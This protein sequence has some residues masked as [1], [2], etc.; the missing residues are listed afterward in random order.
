MRDIPLIILTALDERDAMIDSLHAGADDYYRSRATSRCSR[1]GCAR[2]SAANSSRTSTAKCASAA[3]HRARG[4]RSARRAPRR[5]DSRRAGRRTG[6]K[7]K[8]LEAFSYSV[9]HDLRAPLRTI[10]GFSLAILEDYG[11]KLDDQGLAHLKRVRGAAQRMG[12]LIDDLLEL[13]RVGRTELRRAT[14]NLT[15]LA[16]LVADELVKREPERAVSFVAEQSAVAFADSRLMQVLFDNLLGNAWKFLRAQLLGLN[17]GVS[18]AAGGA[19]FVRDNGAGFDMSY[20]KKL[21]SP[22]QRLHTEA[23]FPGTGIGL[24]TV[25]RIVDR[26]G[27]RVWAEG[28]VGEGATIFFTVSGGLAKREG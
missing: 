27:G 23:D 18:E 1:R 19:Y 4:V 21:F 15:E 7:N 24:A 2:S 26:H 17:F 14:V 6:A 16:R 12:E 5:R 20:A 3:A 9:S 11:D 13:S 28:A 25:H 10:D 8:E 22:F